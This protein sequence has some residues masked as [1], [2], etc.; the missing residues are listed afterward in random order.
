[1]GMPKGGRH[2]SDA[3]KQRQVMYYKHVTSFSCPLEGMPGPRRTLIH[4]N[5]VCL[6]DA[7]RSHYS[8]AVAG[9]VSSGPT[10]PHL[11]PYLPR[12]AFCSGVCAGVR[13]AGSS[14]QGGAPAS[15]VGDGHMSRGGGQ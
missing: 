10:V 12:G 4:V 7:T 11:R 6:R 9:G 15:P 13:Y 2:A 5:S 8:A 14:W 1:M 3:S